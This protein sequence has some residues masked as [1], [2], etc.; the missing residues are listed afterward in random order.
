M[1]AFEPSD[2]KTH[3]ADPHEH[4]N[5]S[6]YLNFFDE[7]GAWGGASRISF[8][9]NQGFADGFVCLFFPG[10]AVGFI[11]VW[12]ACRNHLDRSAAGAIQ[13]TCLEPFAR[14]RL[15]YKGPVYYFDKP[16]S[17]GDFAQ[18]VLT[19][20]PTKEIDLDLEF[21]ALH[22]PF[23]FHASMKREMIP[24]GELAAKLKPSYLLNHLGPAI[25]KVK[26]LRVMSG[27][28][29]YE[30]AGRIEG[31]IKVDGD[32][33][34]L[35]G[36]GQR[37][38]SWGVRDMRVPNAWRWFSCQFG[39]ELCFNATDV[40]LLAFRVSGGYIYH[41]GRS[42]AIKDWS[43]EAE[44]DDSGRWAR[45]LAL[46][47]TAD[48]GKRF[49][50]EGAAMAN[51]PV[52]VNTGGYVSMVNEARARFTWNGQTGHGISEFMGQLF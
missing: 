25:R 28:Q 24:A 52:I 1:L 7:E 23:D 36:R 47:L 19:D 40:K 31:Y 20:L 3:S 9:P 11:R 45:N 21:H 32:A 50:V 26:L 6:F 29:H 13:H 17:M 35:N 39:D 5:E 44:M 27:A 14:W 51:I 38:H 33:R 10:G 34:D 18:S 8:F 30:H 48:S 42:E 15:Q 4:W 41:E 37:D 43:L 22:E 12:E 16:T 2:E 49:D 46:S